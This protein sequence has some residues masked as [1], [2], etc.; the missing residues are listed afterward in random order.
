MKILKDEKEYV[1][2]EIDIEYLDTRCPLMVSIDDTTNTQD[3]DN[4]DPFD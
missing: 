3:N 2:P 1:S 4:P